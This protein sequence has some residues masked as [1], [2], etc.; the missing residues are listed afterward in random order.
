[1]SAASTTALIAVDWGTTAL[2]AYRLTASG[3]V[4]ET[5]RSG[6]GIL[7]VDGAFAAALTR[8][9]EDWTADGAVPVLLS[10]M[11]GSRQGWH[12]TPYLT[13]PCS[14]QQLAD[15]LV[16]LDHPRLDVRVVPGLAD[17]RDGR[18][19][20]MR[21]EEVQVFGAL[22]EAET[23]HF[24]LPGTHSKWV[25]VRD[26]RIVEIRTY[27]TGEI[28]AACRNH[29]IL[30]RLM[31]E[32]GWCESSFRRGVADGAADGTPGA[33]LGRLFGV[34]TAGLFD[35][36]AAGELPDYLSGLLIGAELADAA[37]DGSEPVTIVGDSGLVERYRTAADTLSIACSLGE[38]D[39]SVGAY[40]AI[41]RMAGLLGQ[42]GSRRGV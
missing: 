30:G 19:D 41:A 36:L 26:R 9:V 11:I 1:M 38:S 33:L 27:M 28:Y 32:G 2:R 35:R 13:C 14:L 10:G 23:G 18:D 40:I 34:R 17:H 16:P 25:R 6:D 4:I 21:G 29:T 8:H 39:A 31:D 5:R 24:L 42:S 15:A 20:V 37:G 22:A 7:S 3:D 12:E